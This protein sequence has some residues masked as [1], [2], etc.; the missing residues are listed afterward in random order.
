MKKIT[1]KLKQQKIILIILSCVILFGL[2]FTLIFYQTSL[3]TVD[4]LVAPVSSKITINNKEY[5][6]GQHKLTPG[7][8]EVIISKEDFNTKTF[9]LS[10]KAGKT[11]NLHTFLDQTDGLETWYI[12]HNEDDLIRTQI[13]DE[14]ATKASEKY[15]KKYPIVS[16]LPLIY[17]DYDDNYNYTEYRIDG[18]KYD[19]CKKEFCLKIT[20]STGGN[21]EKAK[22]FIQENGFDPNDYEIIYEYTPIEPLE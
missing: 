12:N 14:Q 18:G 15:N 7:E 21:E 8:Y 6:N 4:L 3:A 10:L 1:N 2:I 9:K 17:A 20:D 16:V 11:T 5:K 19:E 13:G 22:R